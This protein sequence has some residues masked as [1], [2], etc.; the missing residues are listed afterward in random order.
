MDTLNRSALV[1]KPRQRFLDWL[2]TADSTSQGITFLDVTEEPT[3]YLI[4][5]CDTD[6]DLAD[7]LRELCEEIFEEQLESWYRDTSAWPQDR[8]Y[9]VFC[10]WFEYQHY[11]MLIDLCDEP[12]IRD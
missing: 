2:H 12:L 9:E 6:E 11:S 3:M 8:S 1:V 7:V 4:P 10:Q 5:E